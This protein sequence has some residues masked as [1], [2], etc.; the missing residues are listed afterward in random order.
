MN[1]SS[2]MKKTTVAALLCIA[3]GISFAQTTLTPAA[4]RISDT[5]IQ[6]DHAA[7]A[8]MQER[9]KLLNEGG[10][11]LRDYHLSKAQCWLNVSFH[12]YTRNDRSAFPQLALTEA[13]KLVVAMEGKAAPLSM[14]TPLINEATRLRPDLWDLLNGMK[15]GARFS[16][17]EQQVACAEVELVHAGNEYKQLQWQH[18]QPYVQIAED[19]TASAQSLIAQCQPAVVPQPVA[20]AAPV[21]PA[22]EPLTANVVFDFNRAEAKNIRKDSV[23]QLEQLVQRIKTDAL[24]VQSVSLIGYADRLNGTGKNDY[25]QRLAE[26]RAST[27]RT[28]LIGMGIDGKLVQSSGKG[29]TQQV[30]ACE[31]RFKS[32]ADLQE[33]LLPN[34]RVGVVINLAR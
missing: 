8:Q 22:L 4:D 12:E 10:R 19:L 26:R 15:A 24:N 29:D 2:S 3:T 18:A 31:G 16:C 30:V 11:K 13:E 23:V 25:N 5:A 28:V 14:D 34:R 17:A 6:A 32:A 7:Y 33:C 1:P 27:V 9:L 20:V 21:I